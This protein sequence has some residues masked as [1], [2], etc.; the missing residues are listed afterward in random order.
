MDASTS[1]SIQDI[2]DQRRDLR[3]QRIDAILKEFDTLDS[4]IDANESYI[5]LCYKYEQIYSLWVYV[6]RDF[7]P[8]ELTNEEATVWRLMPAIILCYKYYL[9]K[10][11]EIMDKAG[12]NMDDRP[13]R[14]LRS[15][16]KSSIKSDLIFIRR[17]ISK[18]S[19]FLNLKKRNSSSEESI[20][21]TEKIKLSIKSENKLK[22]FSENELKQEWKNLIKKFRKA[23]AQCIQCSSSNTF[24]LV[25]NKK[26]QKWIKQVKKLVSEIEKSSII[27][28]DIKNHTDNAENLAE[29]D[30]IERRERSRTQKESER[31]E[32]EI[33]DEITIE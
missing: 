25:S 1:Q 5:N 18:I 20:A 29:I 6:H 17:I 11:R 10:K 8:D 7:Q 15:L 24:T 26:K 12:I 30:L 28:N 14:T 13:V 3:I 4:M 27:D 16:P 19:Q 33:E 32:G 31:T 22:K 9:I 2:V 21:S 23:T